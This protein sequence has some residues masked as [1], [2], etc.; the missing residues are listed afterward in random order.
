MEAWS[1]LHGSLLACLTP[2]GKDIGVV[3]MEAW[4]PAACFSSQR[5][6]GQPNTL[7]ILELHASC[8]DVGLVNMDAY[9]TISL[10]AECSL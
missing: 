3:C 5:H 1:S 6:G 9:K 10:V 4:R 7:K 2:G 8:K